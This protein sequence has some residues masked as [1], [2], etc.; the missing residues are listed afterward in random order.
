MLVETWIPGDRE[1]RRSRFIR[2]R[3]RSHCFAH[4][5]GVA[6]GIKYIVHD[7]ETQANATTVFGIERRSSSLAPP[8]AAPMLRLASIRADVLFKW[9]YS[10]SVSLMNDFL[11]S[12]PP[13]DHLSVFGSQRFPKGSLSVQQPNWFA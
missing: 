6:G 2:R 3:I 10:S 4:G 8:I 12:C 5:L 11:L 7:L 9:I 1:Q 13:S